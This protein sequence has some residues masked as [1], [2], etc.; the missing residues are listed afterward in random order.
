MSFSAATAVRDLCFFLF[1]YLLLFPF[2]S[3]AEILIEPHVGFHGVFQLGRPFPLEVELSNT[4]RPVEGALEV[5][6]WKA[7]VV[8][9][10]APYPLDY[11][12]EVFLSS[13]SK[14]NIQVTVDPDFISRPLTLAFNSPDA[15]ATRELDLRRYFSPAP[16]ILL[17]SEGNTAP[18]ISLGPSSRTRL[19]SLS[20]SELPSDSRALLGVSHLILYDL[21]LR[22]LSRSQLLALDNWIISGGQMIILGSINSALYQEANFNRFLPVRVT[23]V[24]RVSSLWNLNAGEKVSPITDAWA[25]TS[26]VIE[27]KVVAEAQGIPLL[28]ETSRGKGKISYLALDVGRPPLSRWDGLPNLF[29]HLLA[30]TVES[31]T[32]PRTQWDNS[33]FTQLIQSPS[34]ISSYVPAGSFFLAILTY[35]ILIGVITWLWQRKRWPEQMLL[36]GFVLFVTASA[37]AGYVFFSRGGNIPDGVLVTSTVLESVADGYVEGQSDVALF[38]TQIRQYNLQMERGWLDFVPVEARSRA[39]D[40][41]GVVLQ[42]GGAASRFQLQ[43]KEWDY[44]LFKPRFMER[45]PLRVEFEQQADKLIMRVN[46][47]SSKDLTECWLVV[48]GRRFPLGELPRGAKW[49]KE[50]SLASDNTR[51]ETAAPRADSVNFRDV[52]FADR[53]RD[54]LFHSSFFPRDG[55]WERWGGS[56]V[57][58]GWVKDPDRRLWVDEPRIRASNYTLFRTLVP[59]T[60]P[61]DE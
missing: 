38:S 1:V 34:F 35:L 29:R 15:K 58:F 49:V 13:Q 24:K 40:A 44:R 16:V 56:A 26:S 42:D 43:L 48:P 27:G 32:S 17:V 10:G 55:G 57:F 14:K 6:V 53:T 33:V 54:I 11:R 23:G 36:V 61:E 9:A 31:D 59:L 25:Q 2:S 21:S 30:P 41:S 47:R 20:L 51:E 19:V 50:F 46:N 60:S 8:K 12:K 28:V 37:V 5:R 4:G 18:A 52:S 45:F 39:R 22:E 7:G 3:Q